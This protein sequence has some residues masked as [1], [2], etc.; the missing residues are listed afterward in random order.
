MTAAQRQKAY[1]DRKRNAGRN[2]GDHNASTV[3]RYPEDEDLNLPWPVN[4]DKPLRWGPGV[5][6]YIGPTEV[7]KAA[8]TRL[9]ARVEPESGERAERARRYA[10]Y[11]NF[12]LKPI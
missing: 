10:E 6:V 5:P 4:Q 9:P 1:R 2:G 8:M 11:F 3:T 7:E 12:N